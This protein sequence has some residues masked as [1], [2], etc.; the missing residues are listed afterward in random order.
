VERAVNFEIKRQIALLE[1]GE[2]IA[3]ETRGWL[4]D[5]QKTVSQRSKEDAHDYRYFPDPD[6]PPVVLDNDYIDSIKEVIPIM[7]QEWRVK[8]DALG[9]DHSQ[10]E[11]L[12]EAQVEYEASYLELI[13]AQEKEKA[14]TYVNWLANIEI[15]A[16]KNDI[17][18]AVDDTV[19]AKVFEKVYTLVSSDKINSNSAKALLEEVLVSDGSANITE[20]AESKGFMQESDSSVLEAIVDQVIEDNPGPVEEIKNGETKVIGFLVGQIMKQ[21]RGKANPAVAQKII[22]KKLGV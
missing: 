14:K 3:Q 13:T 16:R 21:S 6:I 9:I 15:P 10:S 18:M 7:P 5:V 8:L 19:R 11:M 2:K 12:L 17:E 20:L 4:D 22:R 1:K